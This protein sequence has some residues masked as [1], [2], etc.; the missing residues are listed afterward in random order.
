MER[1]ELREG[2]DPVSTFIEMPAQ[3]IRSR[4]AA[5]GF[6]RATSVRG[7][8]EV[9]DR[10]HVSDPRYVVR[11]YSSI[12][13]GMDRARGKGSDAIRVVALLVQGN[14]VQPVYSATRIH[15]T[16]SVE[17]VLDR[18]IT[19]AR[20]AYAACKEHRLK[21]PEP[22][23]RGRPLRPD[24]P[25]TPKGKRTRDARN[26]KDMTLSEWREALGAFLHETL[27]IDDALGE[28]DP[29]DLRRAMGPAFQKSVD[30]VLFAKEH[31]AQ[32]FAEQADGRTHS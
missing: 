19:R 27:G 7:N 24:I 10:R 20:E 21:N 28:D 4:L 29:Y 30:P 32:D 18:M 23:G 25:I 11:V 14:V 9:Y 1:E 3:A 6:T 17:G 13:A 15:R 26:P 12:H 8:E 5:A 2:G 16:G 22:E 31:F